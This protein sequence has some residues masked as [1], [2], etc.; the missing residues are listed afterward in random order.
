MG[1]WVMISAGWYYYGPQ[2]DGVG[3]V[4]TCQFGDASGN[5]Y[6]TREQYRAGLA[7][8]KKRNEGVFEDGLYKRNPGVP[9]LPV[10]DANEALFEFIRGRPIAYPPTG[11]MH[12]ILINSNGVPWMP[13]DG[14]PGVG[15]R[16]L[17]TYGLCRYRAAQY[18]LEPGAKFV[19]QGRGIYFV[20]S[21]KGAVEN[22]TYVEYTTIYLEED[23]Q[24]AFTASEVSVVLYLGMPTQSA[25]EKVSSAVQQLQAQQAASEALPSLP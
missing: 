17:G 6:A 10:Q 13:V 5:G 18:K 24:T 3:I 23:E 22:E 25:I 9:G 20:L 11:Y 12:T 14:F 7:E 21:G 16:E 4:V 2:K 8:L 15:E 1:A 19:A